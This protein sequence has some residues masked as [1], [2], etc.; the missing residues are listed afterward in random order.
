MNHYLIIL[1][2]GTK[3]LVKAD[4]FY[5]ASDAMQ[6]CNELTEELIAYFKTEEI[7]GCTKINIE[8]LD[9]IL[10]FLEGD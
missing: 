8:E 3:I 4:K 2:H 9:D 1:K 5:I 7:V 6:F 10:N